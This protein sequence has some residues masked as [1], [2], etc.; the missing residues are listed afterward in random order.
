MLELC[1]FMDM[2]NDNDVDGVVL[3]IIIGTRLLIHWKHSRRPNIHT[4]QE[5]WEK[6]VSPSISYCYFIFLCHNRRSW[7]LVHRCSSGNRC[8]WI[9]SFHWTCPHRCDTTYSV[10]MVNLTLIRYIVC[11]NSCER[12]RGG[13]VV[14]TKSTENAKWNK[15]KM[16]KNFVW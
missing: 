14:L 6:I 10:H 4:A 11:F 8:Q 12:M 7:T 2:E 16:G 9:F 5:R 1:V 15:W 13:A 3:V